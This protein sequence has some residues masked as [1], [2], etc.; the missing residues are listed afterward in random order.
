MDDAT[1]SEPAARLRTLLDRGERAAAVSH[2]EQFADDGVEERKAAVQSLQP[3]AREDAAMLGP[4]CDALLAFLED[5]ERAVRLMTAKLLVSVA[6][7]S[8]DSVVSL[9]PALADRLADDEEF[10]FVRARSA[11]ALGY[12]ALEQPAAAATREVLADLRI[13]LSFDEPEVREK[14]AKALEHV[15]VGDPERLR[16][17]L[18][19]LADHLDDERELIRY[20][21]CT[22]VVAVGAAYPA[23]LSSVHDALTARLDDDNEYVRGR[24]AEALGLLAGTAPEEAPLPGT[25]LESLAA[26]E[27][28][29]LAERALFALRAADGQPD[30]HGQLGTPDAVRETTEAAVEAITT[31]DSEDAC[32]HC[33][34][35][36]PEH[37]PPFCPDCGAPY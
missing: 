19:R 20:H 18:P 10:Y 33:G 24:A 21:L 25:E 12:I 37:G 28:D 27:T 35:P 31:P 9:A 36:L 30:S 13:G 8:P 26:A 7:S 6:E 2:L 34:C 11:E 3:I 4:L 5:D 15:A 23:K 32:P 22:A 16:N 17:H 14:L 1:L 29:L